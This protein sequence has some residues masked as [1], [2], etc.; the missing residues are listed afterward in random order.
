M[1]IR[2]TKRDEAIIDFLNNCKCADTQTLCNIF[3]EF[4]YHLVDIKLIKFYRHFWKNPFDLH[5]T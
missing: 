3:F 2:L 4:T 5:T 1:V